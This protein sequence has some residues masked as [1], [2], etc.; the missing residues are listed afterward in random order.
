M[1]KKTL[2]VALVVAGLIMLLTLPALAHEGGGEGN[3]GGNGDSAPAGSIGG[4]KG[5]SHSTMQQTMQSVRSA[6][7][8]AAQAQALDQAISTGNM[9]DER[10]RETVANLMS[11]INEQAD[12]IEAQI[13]EIQNRYS[14]PKLQG[15]LGKLRKYVSDLRADAARKAEEAM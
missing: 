1:I 11:Q 5:A 6:N 9:G 13:A 10:V 14:S 2:V 12:Q 7:Q 8:L 15:K 3:V 4:G